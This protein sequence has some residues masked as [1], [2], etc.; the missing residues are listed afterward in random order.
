MIRFLIAIPLLVMLLAW[1]FW[2]LFKTFR[3]GIANAA[4]TMHN[5]KE[6]PLMFSLTVLVQLLF[7]GLLTAGLIKLII[8]V[9]NK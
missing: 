4:G 3:T 7:C 5:K 1:L 9:S 6:K 8:E 2:N